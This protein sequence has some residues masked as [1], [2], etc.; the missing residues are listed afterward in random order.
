MNTKNNSEV[1]KRVR[2]FKLKGIDEQPNMKQTIESTSAEEAVLGAVLINPYCFEDIKKILIAGDFWRHR[3]RWIWQAFEALTKSGT[4]IDLLTVSTE[5]ERSGYYEEAG[6]SVYL[7]SLI[8]QVPNSLNAEAYAWTVKEYAKR[9]R[10]SNI[11]QEI[12][13]FAHNVNFPVN[14]ILPSVQGFLSDDELKVVGSNTVVAEVAAL[15]LIEIISSDTP[16]GLPSGLPYLD[17]Q[18]GALPKSETILLAGDSTVGKT[19]FVLQIAETIS[20]NRFDDKGNI[21]KQ[22]KKVLYVSTESKAHTLIARRVCGLAG[23]EQKQ[24]RAGNLTQ[25]QKDLLN[26]KIRDYMDLHSGNL[27]FD[28]VSVTVRDIERSVAAIEPEFI[29]VDHLGELVFENDNKTIG[30]LTG[31]DAL[32][33]IAKK[34]N[35]AQIV[36]HTISADESGMKTEDDIPSFNALGWAKDLRYKADIFLG[37]YPSKQNTGI[38]NLERR[39]LW[40]LKDR[41][42]SRLAKI[43]LRFNTIQQWFTDA[44]I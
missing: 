9:R 6:G 21:T 37:L 43:P 31:F 25:A 38:V 22:G 24:L 40:I 26:E 17:Q 27:F 3:S 4:P 2:N 34:H 36:I 18:L 35:A 23:I 41:E 42:G 11:A 32:K 7:T 19:A 5:L 33:N 16:L 30:L 39:L 44:T 12:V 15:N 1:A 8:N 14:D 13:S 20:G 28:D 29:V 10:W